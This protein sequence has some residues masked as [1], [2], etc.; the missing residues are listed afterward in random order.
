MLDEAAKHPDATVRKRVK[1]VQDRIAVAEAVAP[2]RLSLKFKDV[3]IADALKALG[4]QAGM[5][6]V[7]V[8][9]PSPNVTPPKTVTLEL[10]GVTFL[11]ALDRLCQSAGLNFVPNASR[12]WQ[13]F[14]GKP[15][16]REMAAFS[17]PFH[18][19]ATNLQFSRSLALQGKEQASESLHLQLLLVSELR[20]ALVGSGQPR[21]V[22]ARDAAGR[23]L[24]LDP[25]APAPPT[26]DFF[27]PVGF[28]PTR[29]VLLQPPP[30]RGGTLKHLK[31]ALPIE[32]MARRRD[33]LT[34]PDFGKAGGKT[35]AGD[36]GVRLTVQSVNVFGVN[37]VQV[38]FAVSAPEGRTLDPNGLGLRLIDAKGGEHQTSFFNIQPFA[39]N[40][41]QL[42]AEDLLWLTGSPQR[43][44]PAQL[45]WAALA[46]GGR[47]LDRRQWIGNA[48][49]FTQQPTG[50]PAKL[51][52]FRFER[53][54][55]ELSFEFRDL[56]LP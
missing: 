44:F 43:G 41:R 1:E 37:Y 50:T 55:T 35:F 23:S 20:P 6:L 5:Q 3:P 42:E 53:L 52:L 2:R 48:Q 32:V 11:E 13:L 4:E 54:R 19:L 28:N 12:Q 29:T 22:E 26:G 30:V 39:R 31:V 18:M 56:P 17:G 38:Q 21:V 49:F 36:D 9:S 27:S 34:V 8:S 16:P 24:L 25:Q 46:P 14:D 10:D 7:Y 51:T 33:A 15:S 40:V 47:K 45:P